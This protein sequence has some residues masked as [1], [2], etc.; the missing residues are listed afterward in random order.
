MRNSRLSRKPPDDDLMT[1]ACTAADVAP[2]LSESD[3]E[4]ARLAIA[5]HESGHAVAAL[6]LGLAVTS[7]RACANWRTLEGFCRYGARPAR[8]SSRDFLAARAIAALAGPAAQRHHDPKSWQRQQSESDHL[9]AEISAAGISTSPAGATA[10]LRHFEVTARDMVREGWP[11]IE[12]LA[13]RL[14]AE[15]ALLGAEVEA[16]LRVADAAREADLTLV[17]AMIAEGHPD[18]VRPQKSR[19]ARFNYR[20]HREAAA[21]NRRQ[22]AAAALRAVEK[23]GAGALQEEIL[24]QLVASGFDQ[25]LASLAVAGIAEGAVGT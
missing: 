4:R 10:L 16:I 15:R 5:Y 18:T 12:M 6:R 20:G 7:V 3:A 13:S 9:H 17:R 22:L 25:R 11:V 2:A 19:W 14:F 1:I 24:A 21:P 23:M 8:M